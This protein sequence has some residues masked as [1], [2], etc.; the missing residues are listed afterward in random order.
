MTVQANVSTNRTVT[1]NEARRA[2]LRCFKS[3][4]P[5]FLWGPM[6][7]GKSELIAEIATEMGGL[8]IDLRMATM[9]P[10]PLRQSLPGAGLRSARLLPYR[11]L[12]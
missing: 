9:E 2:I 7:I 6:G 11:G 10:T 1:A 3:K 12:F 8:V 4:R 5:V